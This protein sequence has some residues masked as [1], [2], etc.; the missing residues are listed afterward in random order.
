MCDMEKCYCDTDLCN[1]QS[2]IK[3]GTLAPVIAF[4]IALKFFN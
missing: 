1:G 3:A 4:I 2:P